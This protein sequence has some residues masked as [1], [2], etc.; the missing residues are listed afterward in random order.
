MVSSTRMTRSLVDPAWRMLCA[1]E[2]A[3]QTY[4]L[5]E[6][7]IVAYASLRRSTEKSLAAAIRTD[8]IYWKFILM[9]IRKIS[10]NRTQVYF[11]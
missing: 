5:A 3:P 2:I 4:S 6:C 11:C 7:S 10:K 1:A 8:V 9:M